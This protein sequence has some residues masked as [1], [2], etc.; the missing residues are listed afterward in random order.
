MRIKIWTNKYM[1][2]PVAH[3]SSGCMRKNSNQQTVSN[4][5]KGGGFSHFTFAASLLLF[6]LSPLPFHLYNEIFL[7]L[8][9]VTASISFTATEAKIVKALREWIKSK[10]GILGELVSCGYCFG[11]WIAFALV[12]IYQPKLFELWWLLDYFFN[13]IGYCLVCCFSMGFD[14]VL[15]DGKKG[16]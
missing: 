11:H 15:V 2:R 3:C 16:K 1:L 5:Q 13:G 9:I 10:N 12:A 7:Y 14:V 4:W 8:S 6:H